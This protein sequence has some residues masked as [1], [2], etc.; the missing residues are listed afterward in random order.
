MQL[1]TEVKYEALKL[2]T[3]TIM[4]IKTRH[5]ANAIYM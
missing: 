5:F 4:V 3:S 2:Q 1:K